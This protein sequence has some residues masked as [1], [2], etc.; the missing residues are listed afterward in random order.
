MAEVRAAEAEV[1]A[2]RP[3]WIRATSRLSAANAA[4]KKATRA[5]AAADLQMKINIAMPDT[6]KI[7]IEKKEEDEDESEDEEKDKDGDGDSDSD[8]SSDDDSKSEI[9]QSDEPNIAAVATIES[10]DDKKKETSGTITGM[11]LKPE[12]D[13]KFKECIVEHSKIKEDTVNTGA[14]RCSP[15][16]KVMT[17]S[18]PGSSKDQPGIGDV[19]ITADDINKID[20]S[21]IKKKRTKIATPK[22]W[23]AACW[24]RHNKW[25]GG[26]AHL[27]AP[28]CKKAGDW[29]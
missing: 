6:K 22:G 5:N 26:P 16:D 29:S 25:K 15:D 24:Y 1:N 11:Q 10:S 18:M 17:Q 27:R 8:S 19:N 23:C 20:A 4:Y 9:K 28:P 2:L 3:Q 12:P 13:E 7:K 21:P 14:K